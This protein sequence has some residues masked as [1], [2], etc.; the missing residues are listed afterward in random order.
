ML[1]GRTALVTGASRGIGEAVVRVLA[2]EGARVALT[3]RSSGA[4]DALVHELGARHMAIA[5]DLMIDRD[6]AVL[7]ARVSEWAGGAPDILV[8]NAGTFPRAAA[9]EQDPDEFARTLDL[10]LAAPFRVL[11]AFLPQM[12]ARHTGDIVTLGSVADRHAWP[13]NAAYSASKFGARALHEVLRAETRGTGVR[14]M[15][16]APGPVDTAIWNLHEQE[17]GRSLPRRETMLRAE[18]VARAVLFAVSQP[19]NVDI[20]EL[21]L[22]SS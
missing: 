19:A 4:L 22:S 3:A 18:D 13:A 6:V 10:N 16:V 14:A 20:E 17:L 21:R 5:A 7:A 2:A 11:R 15:L 9:H 12:R 8:N 1:A